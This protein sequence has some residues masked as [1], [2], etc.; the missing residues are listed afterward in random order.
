MH[1]DGVIDL[2]LN[3]HKTYTRA[4]ALE[5]SKVRMHLQLVLDLVHEPHLVLH[6][7][8]FFEDH[9]SAALVTLVPPSKRHASGTDHH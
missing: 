7:A 6:I 4:D 8:R 5:F 9:T 2:W 3:I 1:D